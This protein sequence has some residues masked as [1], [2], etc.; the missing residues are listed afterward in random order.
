LIEWAS[1]LDVPILSVHY[2]LAP[3][4]PF[5]RSLEEIFNVYCWV[6][7]HPD[8]VGSTGE[9]IIFV[10]D[11]A[12]ANMLAACIIRCI[13]TGTRIPK[14]FCSIYGVFQLNFVMSP[15]RLMSVIDLLT[16]SLNFVAMMEAYSG[17]FANFLRSLEGNASITGQ[18]TQNYLAAGE[19]PKVHHLSPN[20]AVNDILAQ[21]PTT[22]LVST[23]LDPVL[24]D[25]VEFGENL[26]SAGVKVKLEVIE[27]IGH[28][29]LV[30][31]KVIYKLKCS[32]YYVP[33]NLLFI[34]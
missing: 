3:D 5:P 16:S 4:A 27:G 13:E 25:S 32:I 9:N 20:L 1:K 8:L 2:S 30:F 19:F 14:G 11:S 26:K 21:F 34:S 28:G 15:S 22:I 6:L 29:F 23:N 33:I 24:D 10:G 17:K 12:G 7:E 31:A 18:E